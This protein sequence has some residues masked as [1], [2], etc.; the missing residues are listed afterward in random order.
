MATNRKLVAIPQK[1]IK[2]K[3]VVGNPAVAIR[4]AIQAGEL[5]TNKDG[6]PL[7]GQTIV[8]G[9][10]Y[11]KV[12]KRTVHTRN[13]PQPDGTVKTDSWPAL[14]GEFECVN[15]LGTTAH[16]APMAFLQ[17]H[18]IE[19]IGMELE[20]AAEQG[21]EN[22]TLLIAYE[23]QAQTSDSAS[24]GFVWQLQPKM[25]MSPQSDPLS[26]LRAIAKGEEQA[27]VPAPDLTA[28]ALAAPS[29]TPS[30]DETPAP[31]LETVDA[32]DTDAGEL[33]PAYAGG[34]YGRSDK[35]KKHR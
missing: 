9:Y 14:L 11:G 20:H 35:R 1:A 32:N 12:V 31:E 6:A 30:A 23:I 22:P 28:P 5:E 21:V 17:D 16:R 26:Q 25:E 10:L 8:L 24:A 4:K 15:V 18:I 2:I 34:D 27:A 33:E 3:A 7:S 13:V 29:E 19:M